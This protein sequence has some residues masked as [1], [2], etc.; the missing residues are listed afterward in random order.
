LVVPAIFTRQGGPVTDAV[1][2]ERVEPA[3]V[4]TLTEIDVTLPGPV[5]AVAAP[6]GCVATGR[7]VK[8]QEAVPS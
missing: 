2:R 6:A 4:A 1:R 8:S 7:T 3:C 5:P